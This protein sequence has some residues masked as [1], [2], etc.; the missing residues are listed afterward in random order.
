MTLVE[1]WDALDAHEWKPEHKN[2]HEF[3]L[4]KIAERRLRDRQHLST[5]HKELYNAFFMYKILNP[6]NEGLKPPR[7]VVANLG[8]D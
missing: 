4:H 3:Q 8:K 2:N 5:K 7:P 6:A 1:Y